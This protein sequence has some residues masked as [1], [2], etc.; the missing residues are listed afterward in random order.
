MD[1][2]NHERHERFQT[3]FPEEIQKQFFTSTEARSRTRG[4]PGKIECRK[5]PLFLS[6][7][8]DALYTN[9]GALIGATGAGWGLQRIARQKSETADMTA[10][11]AVQRACSLMPR[12][13]C[14]NDPCPTGHS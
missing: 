4:A 6:S 9:T 1:R 8:R 7:R 2:D 13:S 11:M 10:A 5:A 3:R 14:E 12:P